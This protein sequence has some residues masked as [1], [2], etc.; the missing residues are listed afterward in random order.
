MMLTIRADGA[1]A[2]QSLRTALGQAGDFELSELGDDT[3]VT[4]EAGDSEALATALAVWLRGQ[5]PGSELTVETSTQ[6]VTVHAG[7]PRAGI[8]LTEAVT[9]AGGDES[10]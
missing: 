8:A 6:V 9:R 3:V 7:D 2:A 4:A 1:E 10:D 5:P